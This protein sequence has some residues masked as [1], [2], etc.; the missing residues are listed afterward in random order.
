MTVRSGSFEAT[1]DTGTMFPM[2][3]GEKRRPNSGN[4]VESPKRKPIDYQVCTNRNKT[5]IAYAV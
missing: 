4:L 5:S 3:L 1:G 2:Y